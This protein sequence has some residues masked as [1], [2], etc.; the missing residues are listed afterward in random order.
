MT[1]SISPLVT[2][3][4]IHSAQ[5]TKKNNLHKKFEKF[6]PLQFCKK[7]FKSLQD[8]TS[9]PS[10]MKEV[11][12]LNLECSS[13]LT[14]IL[15]KAKSFSQI[16]KYPSFVLLSKRIEKTYSNVK[17]RKTQVHYCSLQDFYR[18]RQVFN[19]LQIVSQTSSISCGVLIGTHKNPCLSDGYFVALIFK[20]SGGA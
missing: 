4:L 11:Q 13:L 10:L 2:E 19:F 5:V 8:K 3:P 20:G 16:Q 12:Q 15:P 14:N 9:E 6:L 1:I 7:I 17:S 18:H